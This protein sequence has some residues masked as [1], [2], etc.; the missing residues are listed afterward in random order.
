MEASFFVNAEALKRIK[1]NIEPDEAGYLSAFDTNR[2]LIYAVAVKV[3]A[4]R[5]KGSY[6]LIGADF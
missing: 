2:D 4:R 5:H 3:F 1:P 6:D